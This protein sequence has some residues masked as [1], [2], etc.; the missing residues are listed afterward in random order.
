[1]SHT[2]SFQNYT[3]TLNGYGT[4]KNT[5]KSNN[6]DYN[7]LLQQNKFTLNNYKIWTFGQDMFGFYKNNDFLVIVNS[8]GHGSLREGTDFAYYSTHFAIDE[9]KQNFHL[10]KSLYI[11]N[12]S[13]IKSFMNNIF[14]KLD[15]ILL[16]EFPE[17][18]Y[19][20]TGGTTL[21]V[22]I[23][24]KINNKLV[25]IVTNTGD[26]LFVRYDNNKIKEETSQLNCDTLENYQ[27][28]VHKC[29][30]KQ[31]K[32]KNIY[33]ARFNVTNKS[34]KIP[35]V[36]KPPQPIQ[37]FKLTQDKN[38]NY[39]ASDN[40]EVMKIFYEK[41]NNYF[42]ENVLKKGGTQ[43]IRDLDL[44][45]SLIKEG[46]YPSTNFGNTAEGICQCLPG[47]SIGD[48]VQK[49]DK[50]SMISHTSIHIY[51]TRKTREIIGSDGF[52]DPLSD[53]SLIECYD[54]HISHHK[55]NLLQKMYDETKNHKWNQYWDDIS[56]CVIDIVN[57]TK[58]KKNKF[59]KKKQNRKRRKQL[60]KYK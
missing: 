46:K 4:N 58:P 40:I 8:D 33:L 20:A 13:K 56:M 36:S 50:D 22:N 42:K 7:S 37:P 18:C 25:S 45:K 43:T 34:F 6:T 1:M 28:Y 41:A 35:W 30:Q 27:L 52:F 29:N 17:T 32:P 53:K 3:I 23:K 26:S 31:I 2:F 55:D 59:E 9:I 57:N 38:N 11:E 60:N 48:I 47:A 16:Y 14:Q 54:S 44:N 15:N 39:I 12:P 19:H 5:K 49:T 10:I 24:F 21:T 51:N